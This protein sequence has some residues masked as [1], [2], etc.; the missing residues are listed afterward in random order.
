MYPTTK[1]ISVAMAMPHA[2]SVKLGRRETC[3]RIIPFRFS[4]SKFLISGFSAAVSYQVMID[5]GE[6]P[7]KE[8]SLYAKGQAS[9]P[10]HS[11]RELT[12]YVRETHPV[13]HTVPDYRAALRFFLL[14][15]SKVQ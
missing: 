8:M 11:W 10:H 3:V 5:P 15:Y 2:R 13:S 12:I 6:L 4:A 9:A 14:R 1:A 7:L